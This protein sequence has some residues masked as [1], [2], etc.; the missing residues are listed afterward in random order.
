[1]EERET[2]DIGLSVFPRARSGPESLSPRPSY[3]TPVER[4]VPH[5]HCPECGTSIGVK[6]EYSSKEC[7]KTHKDRLAAKKRQLLFLYFG[8]VTLFALAMFLTFSG[9]Q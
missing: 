2:P 5:K 7:E 3:A 4:V 1:M 6:D 8:G 9:G